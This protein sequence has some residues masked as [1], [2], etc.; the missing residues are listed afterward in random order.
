MGD[1]RASMQ[2]CVA[3]HP[4]PGDAASHVAERCRTFSPVRVE[5]GL[6]PADAA[7]N[8]AAGERRRPVT[9]GQSNVIRF[10]APG[11]PGTAVTGG[12]FAES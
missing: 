3:R 9:G 5:Q 1:Y 10:E 4:G 8:S 2:V 6:L 7:E 12:L 11:E